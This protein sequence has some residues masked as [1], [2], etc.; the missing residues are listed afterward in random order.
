MNA[1]TLRQERSSE[2][3]NGADR[4]KAVGHVQRLPREPHLPVPPL[5][6]GSLAQ[7]FL[8]HAFGWCRH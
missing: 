7:S 2:R 3:E 4:I 5:D 8:A 1:D 6:V